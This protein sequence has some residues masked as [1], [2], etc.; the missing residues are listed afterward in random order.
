MN[1]YLWISF[2]GTAKNENIEE[3]FFPSAA[4]NDKSRHEKTHR[5]KNK[6]WKIEVHDVAAHWTFRLTNYKPRQ[7]IKIYVKK[8]ILSKES[9]L[10]TEFE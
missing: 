3:K 10:I 4:L 9:D 1:I 2:I 7:I 5:G 6:N 8:I